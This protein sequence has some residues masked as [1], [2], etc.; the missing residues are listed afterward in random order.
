MV[1]MS[2]RITMVLDDDLAKKLRAIQAK[3]IQKNIKSVSFSKVL[4]LYLRIGL[5]NESKRR[6]KKK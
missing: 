4:N 3:M 2:P 1:K 6:K 5:S